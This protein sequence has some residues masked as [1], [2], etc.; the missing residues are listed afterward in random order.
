M[1]PGYAGN[2]FA[3]LGMEVVAKFDRSRPIWPSS[4][5]SGWKSGVDRLTTRPNGRQPI[6]GVGRH[7]RN[8]TPF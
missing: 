1:T 2:R 8:P 6:A 4:P 7:S 3:V 5:A